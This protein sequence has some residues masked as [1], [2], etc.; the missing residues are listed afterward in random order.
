MSRMV[1]TRLPS[2]ATTSSS[3]SLLLHR[4]PADG[5]LP[6]AG[7]H[8]QRRLLQLADGRRVDRFS[9][10]RCR[11]HLGRLLGKQL[12]PP[13]RS[14]GRVADRPMAVRPHMAVHVPIGG[15]GHIANRTLEGPFAAV[16]QHV[17][18]QTARTA[19]RLPAKATGVRVIVG[20]VRANVQRKGVLRI[21]LQPANG[22]L[23]LLLAHEGD[24]AHQA[25]RPEAVLDLLVVLV[26][27]SVHHQQPV[28][29][30][31]QAL[32][33]LLLVVQVIVII[34]TVVLDHPALII[35]LGDGRRRRL[36]RR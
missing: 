24:V 11:R 12:R 21:E 28:F 18:I 20:I 32:L 27:V 6:I 9:G 30:H 13:L 25:E 1:S 14:P 36:S 35:L 23:E 15:E 3:P 22:A 29:V 19:Q 2:T 8:L 34:V 10:R 4:R 26:L 7:G 33:F 17:S 5:A 31:H 16:N